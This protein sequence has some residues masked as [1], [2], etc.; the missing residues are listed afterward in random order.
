MGATSNEDFIADGSRDSIKGIGFAMHRTAKLEAIKA[1]TLGVTEQLL[2]SKDMPIKIEDFVKAEV[3]QEIGDH[4]T[5]GG[6]SS[7]SSGIRVKKEEIKEEPGS[8]GNVKMEG[9]A[10]VEPKEEPAG[11]PAS[12]DVG[13]Q[14]RPLDDGDESVH[15]KQKKE[16]KKD[17]SGK[18]E[19]KKQKK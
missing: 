11:D 7:S 12:G 4:F 1:Q 2:G 6:G 8:E 9:E 3:K 13:A 10:K 17:K 14:K 16:K 18:K 5:L 15:K 19:K